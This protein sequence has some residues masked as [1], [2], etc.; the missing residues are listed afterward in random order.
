MRARRDSV[1]WLDL[2]R[3][4]SGVVSTVCNSLQPILALLGHPLAG[5]PRQYMF[6][7]AFAQRE[8]DWR[9]LTLEVAPARLEEAVRGFDAL[10][11]RGGN[12]AP[13]FKTAIGPLL[14]RQSRTAELSGVVNCI[15]RQEEQLVGENTEGLAVLETLRQRIDP[16]GKHVVLFGTGQIGRAIGVELATAGVGQL[17]IINRDAARAQAFVEQLTAAFP[18]PVIPLPWDDALAL[19]AETEVLIN[20]SSL[21]EGESDEPFPLNLDT[22]PSGLLVVDVVTTPPQTWLVRHCEER[23]FKTING[24]EIFV[25][26]AALDFHLWTGIEPDRTVLREAVEEFLEL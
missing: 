21:G 11:F 22:L 16:A 4:L 7:K 8:L 24:L 6:E 12:C 23:G 5:N 10:G 13:P 15:H 17:V 3:L 9:Y 20:A 25:A 26:Q 1:V 19:P 2:R 18:V 14:A